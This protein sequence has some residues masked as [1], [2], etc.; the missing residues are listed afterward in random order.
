MG[1]RV[2]GRGDITDGVFM[3]DTARTAIEYDDWV[4]DPGN[5]ASHVGALG[6]E[7]E[8]GV[9]A[10]AL[11]VPRQYGDRAPRGPRPVLGVRSGHRPPRTESCSRARGWRCRMGGRSTS[12]TG[13]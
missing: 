2:D 7:S 13:G 10:P 8:A 5:L 1:A 4:D 9:R 12:T 11:A 3:D 6:A